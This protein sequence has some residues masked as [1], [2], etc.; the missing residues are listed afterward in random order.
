MPEAA[1]NAIP[2]GVAAKM[3]A[4]I[5]KG[6]ATKKLRSETV[7]K[8][9]KGLLQSGK[10]GKLYDKYPATPA[11]FAEWKKQADA[12]WDEIG[13]M[14]DTCDPAILKKLGYEK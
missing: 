3:L 14:A 12:L 8:I 1:E 13:G 9:V 10:V 6:I 11:G 4:V 7:G 2:S 5:T